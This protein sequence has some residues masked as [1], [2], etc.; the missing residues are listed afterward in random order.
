MATQLPRKKQQYNEI[1]A[2]LGKKLEIANVMAIPAITKIVINVGAGKAKDDNALLE[3]LTADL[4]N[5]SGQKPMVTKT[6]NAIANFKVRENQ[7][8]GVKVTLRGNRM[9]E[10]YDKLVSVVLPRV[11]DFRGVSAKAFDGRGNYA[12]GF[13]DQ[14]VFP[15]IDTTKVM[16]YHP[17]QVIIC[18]SAANNEQGFELLSTLGMPFKKDKKKQ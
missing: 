2:E 8:V 18:T 13:T 11:K 14:S 17:L 4:A 10:F 6:K 16:K 1:K 5:I 7:A 12:L 15:E 3:Q 9:W